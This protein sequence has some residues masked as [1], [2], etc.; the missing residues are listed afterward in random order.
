VRE[1]SSPTIQGHGEE[2]PDRNLATRLN[3]RSSLLGEGS[4]TLDPPS[5]GLSTN[6]VVGIL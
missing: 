6:L 3:L 2:S 1:S 4:P 5:I